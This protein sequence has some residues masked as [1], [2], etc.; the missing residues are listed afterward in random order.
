MRR[1]VIIGGVAGGMSTATRLR[2]LDETA[3]IVVVERSGF[4]SYA[5]CGLPYYIGGVISKEQDL[6]LQTPESLNRRFNLDVRVNSEATA[7]DPNTKS[8]TIRNTLTSNTYKLEYDKFIYEAD[9]KTVL[10]HS[11]L[12]KIDNMVDSVMS[13]PIAS[14]LITASISRETTIEWTNE[15]TDIPMKGIID[16]IGTEYMFDIKTCQDADPARFARDAFYSNYHRQAAIYLDSH[17]DKKMTEF[18]FIAI[19]KDAPYG[20]SVHR[21][22]DYILELGKKQYIDTIIEYRSWVEAGMLDQ[23]YEYWHYSGIHELETPFAR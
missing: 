21:C 1:I 2:R 4:V 12:S 11:D 20:V 8:V 3:E 10:S 22:T 18:Y 13:N 14:E 17:K 15:E 5:N 16:G 7:I 19:E 6:L 23:G 9:G